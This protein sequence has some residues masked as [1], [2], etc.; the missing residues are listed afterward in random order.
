MTGAAQK[1]MW[2]CGT[3]AV[4]KTVPHPKLLAQEDI[5]QEVD[6]MTGRIAQTRPRLTDKDQNFATTPAIG[7]IERKLPIVSA[8]TRSRILLLWAEPPMSAGDSSTPAP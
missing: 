4:L 5:G 7:R 6:Q 2:E 8:C 1:A 3:V